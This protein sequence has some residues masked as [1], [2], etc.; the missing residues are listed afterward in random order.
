MS[1]AEVEDELDRL[2]T[3]IENLVEVINMMYEKPID[4]DTLSVMLITIGVKQCDS[5]KRVLGKDICVRCSK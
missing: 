2:Q 4:E 5:C 1:E 3:K